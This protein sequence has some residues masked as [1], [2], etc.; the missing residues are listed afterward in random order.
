MKAENTKPITA[1]TRIKELLDIDQVGVIAALVKLNSNFS[2]LKNPIL[3]NLLARRV[4]ISDACKI[5]RCDVTSFLDTMEQIGF[6]ID[7][8]IS[9]K[10][11]SPVIGI[12][13]S[14]Q[15]VVYEL[16]VRP[17]LDKNEDP[18]KEILKI[19]GK[20][21]KGERLKIINSFEPSPLISLLGE[22]GFL[23]HTDVIDSKMFLTWFEKKDDD[24]YSDDLLVEEPGQDDKVLFDEILSHFVSEKITYIDVRNLEMPKPMVQI[25]ERIEKMAKDELLYVYH[26]KV[27]VFLLPELNKRGLAYI[28]HQY[29]ASRSDVLI[30]GNELKQTPA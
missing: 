30:Y 21:G 6:V 16:D 2:K 18:L 11:S 20:L 15:A 27:P 7:R 25:M 5:A 19:A 13:F 24:L 8:K 10:Y 23:C 4:T 12:D 28:I 9:E 26:K 22:K 14:R 17:S 3:R 29:S 1:Q